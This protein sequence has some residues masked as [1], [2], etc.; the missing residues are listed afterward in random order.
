[1]ALEADCGASTVLEA[2]YVTRTAGPRAGRT[3]RS[4]R[5][6]ALRNIATPTEG[7]EGAAGALVGQASRLPAGWVS[8]KS[9]I[10]NF[11]ERKFRIPNSEFRI[12]RHQRCRQHLVDVFY[13]N[14][15]EPAAGR[16]REIDQVAFVLGRQHDLGDSRTE[17]G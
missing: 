10:R 12:R 8:N 13:E 1:M 4:P 3:L 9:E 11:E 16:G 15:A 17:G 14:E 5:D 6:E 7:S 2:S